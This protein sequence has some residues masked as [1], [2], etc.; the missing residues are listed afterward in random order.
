MNET[1]STAFLRI[2]RVMWRKRSAGV[3]AAAV[4][5]SCG[6]SMT[7][8]GQSA[9]PDGMPAGEM[10]GEMMRLPSTADTE[11]TAGIYIEDGK[12]VEERSVPGILSGGTLGDAA[13]S[14]VTVA[15]KVD[16]L[17]GV[18]VRGASEYTLSDTAIVI[19]ADGSNDFLGLGAGAMAEGGATLVL[20]NVTVTTTGVT[21]CATVASNKSLL[22]VYDSTL[23]ANGGTLPEDYMPF[24]GPGMKEP[25]APLGISG[26]ARAHVTMDNSESYFYNSTIISNG[27]GA[28]STDSAQG[29]VY[30]E[31]NDCDVRVLRSG[32]GTYADNGC[33]VVINRSS[34][35]TPTYT[36]IMGGDSKITLN[37]TNA[38][39]GEKGFLIHNVN[40]DASVV[41]VLTI[42]GGRVEA[43]DAVFFIKSAN[44]TISA[45]GAA[46]VS[47]SGVLVRTMTN[48]D[49]NAVEV[50][51][52]VP[53][54]HVA[55]TDMHLEG[56]ILHED[57]ART[58]TV[59]LADTTL[60]GVIKKTRVSIDS[61][62]KWT[63]T[64]PSE[65]IFL[66]G[67]DVSR[68]DAPK[69]VVIDAVAGKECG[70]KKG[71]YTLSSGGILNVK[72]E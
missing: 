62:S 32:Y 37:D 65:V 52:E 28:L 54:I 13:V 10:P 27:W 56:D 11:Y 44:A 72:A 46:L 3:A 51:G 23:R 19:D 2:M 53:G 66:K 9:G 7:V 31:A 36:G 20:K 55:L 38:I 43:R 63:A 35:N 67:I 29:Y 14:G 50:N 60:T 34:I 42:S 4:F 40:S 48:D 18:F 58:L 17:N 26:N 69:G 24:I 6:L 47:R 25:P 12:Y 64:G 68:I 33:N 22:K 45:S 39:S 5:F 70:M 49:P 8:F 30:L 21:A 57:K 15:S 1:W 71:R 16:D 41:P 61:G 59:A